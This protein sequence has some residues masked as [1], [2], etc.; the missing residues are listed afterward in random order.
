M[1]LHNVWI[2]IIVAVVVDDY[3]CQS[4]AQF[5]PTAT[6]TAIILV[7]LFYISRTTPN[8]NCGVAVIITLNVYWLALLLLSKVHK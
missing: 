2:Q 1:D 5:D 6:D 7:I 4:L 3:L 8:Q